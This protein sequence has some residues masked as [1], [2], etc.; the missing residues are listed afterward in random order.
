MTLS[1]TP[2]LLRLQALYQ[3]RAKKDKIPRKEYLCLNCLG[4]L[5]RS[6]KIQRSKILL[7][8]SYFLRNQEARNTEIDRNTFSLSLLHIILSRKH[9]RL[10]GFCDFFFPEGEYAK[11]KDTTFADK[12]TSRQIIKGGHYAGGS[13]MEDMSDLDSK[14][15]QT[16][17]YTGR[18]RVPD[19]IIAREKCINHRFCMREDKSIQPF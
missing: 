19:Q 6:L 7:C 14:R 13:T 10:T 8:F 12:R 3:S 18:S 4:S 16:E 1:R 11:N 15:T 2:L 17:G 5:A 9:V